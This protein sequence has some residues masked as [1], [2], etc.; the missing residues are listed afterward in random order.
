MSLIAIVLLEFA[1]FGGAPNTAAFAPIGGPFTLVNGAGDAVTDRDFRGKYM[2]IYFGYTFCPDFCPITLTA[3]A[4]AMDTLHGK[5]ERVRPIFI[6]IDPKRDTPDVVRQYVAA[7]GPEFV[8]LTGTPA[9]IEAVAKKY[10]VYFAAHKAGTGANDYT[11]D[12]SSALY[13]VGPDGRFVAPIGAD[14]SSAKIAADI[15]KYLS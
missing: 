1:M 10:H 7:F 3:V 13:L 15:A 8:G 2:L 5:A 6:T 11:M 14:Q 4:Q 12:H 9:Q